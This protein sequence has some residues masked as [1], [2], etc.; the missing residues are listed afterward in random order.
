M[1]SATKRER[2]ER[3]RVQEVFI[4]P[5]GSMQRLP[6]F[7]SNFHVAIGTSFVRG[8]AN[9]GDGGAVFARRGTGQGNVVRAARF[10]QEQSGDHESA[11]DVRRFDARTHDGRMPEIMAS[12][13]WRRGFGA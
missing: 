9:P 3:V 10:A 6:P 1:T 4:L 13:Q 8:L 2:L 7:R 5:R 12:C 11:E